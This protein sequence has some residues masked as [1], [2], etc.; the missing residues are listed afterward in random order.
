MAKIDF[1]KTSHQITTA[2]AVVTALGILGAA[3][4]VDWP[5]T[6]NS[7]V[8]QQSIEFDEYHDLKMLELEMA[9]KENRQ[10]VILGEMSRIRLYL[11]QYNDKPD[12]T[13]QDYAHKADWET[14]LLALTEEYKAL[15]PK[16]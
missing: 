16:K 5:L 11:T 9:G 12:M 13:P 3:L 4:G 8:I 15:A 2:A 10:R 1:S 14:Q 7:P 6:E